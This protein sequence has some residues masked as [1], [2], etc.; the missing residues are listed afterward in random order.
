MPSLTWSLL[1]LAANGTALPP[2]VTDSAAIDNITVEAAKLPAKTTDLSARVTLIDSE[3]MRRE[4]AQ[5]IAD[6]VRY[7]PGV[8]VVDQGSRFGLSGISIRGIGGNRVKIEV[9]GVPTSDAF[10][11]G[12]FS[13]ASRDFVEIDSL[14]Q[15]EIVRG[16]SSATFGSDALGGVVSFITRG[17]LDL[18][19]EDGRYFDLSAGF[20]SV[21]TSNLLSASAA[22]AAG[23]VGTLLRVSAR[24]GEERDLPGADPLEDDSLN[25]LARFDV[26]DSDAGVFSLTLERFVANSVTDVDS[27]ER[28]QDFSAQFGFPYIIDTTAV[29]G[30]DRRERNRVSVGQ[31]WA[32]G[33]FGTDYFRWRAYFQDSQTTQDTFEARESFIAGIAAAVERDRGFRFDQELAGLEV[34]AA[35]EF[36]TG[37]VAHQLAWGIEF[38]STDTE[39]LRTGTETDLATGDT[40]NQVGPDLFPVRDF[41][42][43]TT[44]RMGVYLQNR[45]DLGAIS[46][47]PG[48]RWDRYRLDPE[49]EPIFIDANPDVPLADYD[50]DQVSPKLGI[51]WDMADRW[52]LYGQYAEGFRAPPVNDVNVGFTNLQFGYTTLPNPDLRSESSKGYEIG[53]RH[54]GEILRL[55]LATFLTRYDDFIESFQ[56]V[57]FDPVRQ[58]VLFQ[59]INVDEVEIRGAELSGTFLPP[60]LPDGWQVNFA[61]AWAEGEDEQTGEPLNSVAPLNGV[62]GLDYTAASERWGGSFV[63]RGAS[64]QDELDES[65]GELLSPPGHVIYDAYGY[66][67]PTDATRLRAGVYNLGDHQYIAYLDVQGVPADTA[68]ADRYRRPGREFNVAFDWSF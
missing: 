15:V 49:A 35:N 21:D 8:D 24:E 12:S 61:M 29:A 54:S 22:F 19:D 58:L 30:D 45:I 9:D 52:Q 67:K 23:P 60:G 53:V 11:I 33:R 20:N 39:Q 26:G 55:D 34:N 40:S 64:R 10:S 3:R 62:L 16:P 14:K 66:W 68:N 31:E 56:T 41:P 42:I 32:D 65:G 25:L 6:L 36:S 57:G 48:L 59:S 51:L 28:V 18:I 1:A 50:D 43:S 47:I 46:V 13:N 27:L 2:S 17:P 5:D 7:E 37:D 38:E 44:K 4:L 63:V